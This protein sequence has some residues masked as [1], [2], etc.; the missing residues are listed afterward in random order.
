[1]NL[2]AVVFNAIGT[3][4]PH[5]QATVRTSTGWTT[6]ASGAR[7]PTYAEA[8]TITVQRQAVDQKDLRLIDGLNLQGIYA[9]IY[10][11]G[12]YYGAARA[13]QQGGDLFEFDDQTWLVTAVLEAWPDWCKVL[14]CQQLP[15]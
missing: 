6:S 1:M 9:T 2:N 3:V 11:D 13:L 15:A 14:V 4:N 5:I 7:V 8:E 10:T 12:R